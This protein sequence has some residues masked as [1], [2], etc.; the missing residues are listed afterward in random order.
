MMTLFCDYTLTCGTVLDD[1]RNITSIAVLM[2]HFF[3]CIKSQ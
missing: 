2:L 3:G 1:R